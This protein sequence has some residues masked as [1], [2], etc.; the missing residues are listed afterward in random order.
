MNTTLD[1]LHLAH[2]SWTDVLRRAQGDA[3]QALGLGPNECSHRVV[4]AG[5]HWRLRDYTDHNTSPCLL[6]VAAPIKRPYIWDLTSSVS[7]IRY[8]LRQRLHV[9]LLEWMPASR[10]SSSNGLDEYIEAIRECVSEISDEALGTKPFLI[11]HSLGGTLAAIFAA[12]VSPGSLCGLVLLGA[13]LCFQPE[14]SQFRDKRRW[15]LGTRERLAFALLL[16]TGQRGGDVVKMVRCDIMDGCIRISAEIRQARP[17]STR[18]RWHQAFPSVPGCRSWQPPI[19]RIQRVNAFNRDVVSVKVCRAP[20]YAPT[21]RG[22]IEGQQVC[23]SGT[24]ETP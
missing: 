21:R 4:A 6:I 16:Y 5:S 23:N 8:C 7:A 17:P 10:D 15:P 1:A 20:G 11:G 14:T 12:S 2:F 9:Y 3:F 22:G 18:P 19:L 24:Q 13:P